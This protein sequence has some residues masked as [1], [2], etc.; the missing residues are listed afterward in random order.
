MNSEKDSIDEVQRQWTRILPALDTSP[1]V[2]TGRIR[3]L[4]EA[5]QAGSDEVLAQQGLTRA[6]FDILSVLV[7]SGRALSPTEIT[8][9]S[10]ISAPGT[11]K[12]IKKLESDG[13][14]NRILNPNDKRGYLIEPTNHALEIFQP[15]VESISD[16]ERTLLGKLEPRDVIQ[17]TESLR[18][19]VS[20]VRESKTESD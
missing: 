16:Y 20:A 8:V 5:I 6:D 14:V 11:T 17:L 4:A 3:Y 15:V 19:F 13:L 10:L 7:R 12:R 18:A 1:M 2:I 9:Q